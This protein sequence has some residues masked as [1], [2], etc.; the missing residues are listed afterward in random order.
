MQLKPRFSGTAVIF[1][2]TEDLKKVAEG[3]RLIAV[4]TVP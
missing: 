1:V 3:L 4:N 2:E